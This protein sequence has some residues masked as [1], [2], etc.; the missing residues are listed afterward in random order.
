[1]RILVFKGA[2]G[3]QKSKRKRH[4][5]KVFK[6]EVKRGEVKNTVL[7]QR[8]HIVANCHFVGTRQKCG[9]IPSLGSYFAIKWI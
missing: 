9:S 5:N 7:H 8:G 1:M 4:G 6:D 3:G 2:A